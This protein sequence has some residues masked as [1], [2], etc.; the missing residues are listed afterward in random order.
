M[1]TI[2]AGQKLDSYDIHLPEQSPTVR[3]EGECRFSN[4]QLATDASTKLC[5][6]NPHEG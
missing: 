5:V 2:G 4:G 6:E 3:I 1:I